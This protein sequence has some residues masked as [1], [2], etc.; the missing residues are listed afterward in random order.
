MNLDD[1]PGT[2]LAIDL[3]GSGI[4]LKMYEQSHNLDRS[5]LT[6]THQNVIPSLTPRVQPCCIQYRMCGYGLI[7]RAN[8]RLV[9]HMQSPRPIPVQAQYKIP[10][11]T[12]FTAT[13]SEH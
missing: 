8:H 6:F 4:H 1:S 10:C 5:V 2:A 13:H 7:S 9:S 12:V 3:V 11:F